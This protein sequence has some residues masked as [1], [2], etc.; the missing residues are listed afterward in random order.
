MLSPPSKK[1]VITRDTMLKVGSRKFMNL[2][3][4]MA[5]SNNVFFEQLGTRMG[6]ETVSRYRPLARPRRTS[7]YNLRMSIRARFQ[8]PPA[9]GGVARI[10]A[11]AKAYKSLRCKWL[12]WLRAF[13]NVEHFIICKFRTARKKFRI[14]RLAS[15]AN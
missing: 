3:E 2:T 12:H 5:P 10:P 7:W 8:S 15:S 14:S 6:F 4:A 13:A 9:Y 1:N 11:A